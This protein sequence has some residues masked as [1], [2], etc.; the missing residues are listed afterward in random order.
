MAAGNNPK[1]QLE[2]DVDSTKARAGFEEVS[3]S[4]QGMARSV[5]ESGRKAGGGLDGVAKGSEQAAQRLDRSTKSIIAQI[6]RVTAEM[7]AGEKG[8][9]TYFESLARQRGANV[10]ALRPYLAQLDAAKSKQNEFSQSLMNTGMSARATAAALRT[11]PAQFTDIVTSLQSGQAP[12][13]VLLQQGGQ[14]NDQFGGVGA[15]AQALGRYIAGLVNPFT[16]AAGAL[17]ALAFAAYQGSEE[18]REFQK[19]LI[20]SGDRAGVTAD[21]LMQI[22]DSIDQMNDGITRARAAEV[23]NEI[24]RS[25]VRG[26]DQIRRL[27]DTAARFEQVGGGA[28]EEVAKAFKALAEDPLGASMK[29]NEAIGYL[30]EST[31]KQIKA[32]VDQGRT[33]EAA[34]LAIG[35]YASAIENRI[36]KLADNLGSIQRAW[37]YVK[38]EAA[39]AWDAMLGIGRAE[40][41]GDR[42]ADIERRLRE[43]VTSAPAFGETYAQREQETQRLRQELFRLR[44]EAARESLGAR[45]RGE[46]AQREKERIAFLA[47]GDKFLDSEAKKQKEIAQI[48]QLRLRNVISE[49]EAKE[50]IA[51]I[52]QS[53]AKG[54][55]SRSGG[56]RSTENR[57]LKEQADLLATLSGVNRDYVEQLARVQSMRESGLITE[58]QSID[59]LIALIEKQPMARDLMNEQAEATKRLAQEQAALAKAEQDRINAA[60]RSAAGVQDQVQKLLDEERALTIAAASNISLAQAI[61]EVNIARLREQQAQLMAQGDRD[62]EVLAIQKEIDARK[63]LQ[64]AIGRQEAREEAKK[65]AD[66][67]AKEWQKTADAIEQTLTDALMRG[68]ESGK[69]FGE[70]LAD[71]IVNTFKTYVAR[72]IAKAI[73]NAILSAIAGQNWANIIG[74]VL[75]G[76]QGGGSFGNIVTSVAGDYAKSAI[77]NYLGAGAGAGAAAAGSTLG[78]ATG[79]GF[80]VSAAGSGFG[81]TATGTGFGVSATTTGAAAVGGG[82]VAGGATTATGGALAGASSALAAIP[83]WGWVAIAAIALWQPLFGRKLKEVGTQINFREGD[84]S[85]NDYKFEKGGWFRS[86]KTTMLGD[87]TDANKQLVQQAENIQESA[88]GM[89]RALGFGT[90]AIDSF[91]GTVNVNMKGV[92]SNEEAAQR[93]NEALMELQRQMLNAATGANMSKEAFAEWINGINQ[94][95][96]DAGISTQGIADILVQGM[97]GRLSQQEVGDQL[98]DMI[99]GGIYNSIASNYA[100]QIAQAF[101]A[102]IITPIFT[103]LAAGVPISQAISQQAIAN[104]VA[105]AQQAAAALNAIFNDAGFKAAIAGVEQAIG[106]VAS[107]ATSVKVPKILSARSSGR[108]SGPSPA[109]IEADRIA[110]EREGLERQ[111]LQLQG[112][113]VELRRRE[114]QELDPSNR[115]L[116]ERIWALEEEQRISQERE[117]IERRM[118]ELNGRQA[119]LRAM[120]LAALDASN[121]AL[122]EHVWALEDQA[123]AASQAAGL[124]RNLMQALGDTAG[125]R[126]ME[127]DAI[128]PSARYLQEALWAVEDAAAAEEK[129]RQKVEEAKSA[130]RDAYERE[131]GEIQQTIDK[132]DAFAR[133]LKAFRQQL[134]IDNNSPLSLTQ[135]QAE[136]ERQ[137]ADVARRARLGDVDAIAELQEISS[138][139]LAVSMESAKSAEDYYRSFAKVQN[140]LDDTESLAQRQIDMAERQLEELQQQVQGLIDINESV[141][142]VE[143]AVRNVNSA[144]SGLAAATIS[145]GSA[146]EAAKKAIEIYKEQ[147]RQEQI[148][149]NAIGGD[150]SAANSVAANEVRALYESIGRVGNIAPSLAEIAYWARQNLSIDELKRTFLTAAS[151]ATGIYAS[152]AEIAQELLKG[153]RGYASGGVHSGGLRIVGENGPELELT[154]PSRIW[155]AE[156]TQRMLS[157]SANDELVAEVRQ[158]RKEMAEMKSA[159]AATARNSNDT[160]KILQRVTNGGNAMLTEAVA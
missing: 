12:L 10:D 69:G 111:L 151:G 51:K 13:T 133:S 102:Q 22:A 62:A 156:Q 38:K 150:S 35:E 87:T 148:A 113:T 23:L 130:L 160:V 91:S 45:D 141:L 122:Q 71:S 54:G 138:D 88:K 144:I 109:Q 75:G 106:G 70:S 20:L 44:T 131:R 110:K 153:I 157:G 55:S 15:A 74:G 124:V 126:Q 26:E 77:S 78:T 37:A 90:D 64:Q 68:F 41:A 9:S 50:R 29:L 99:V 82:A 24:V 159:A 83:V 95:I 80:G 72:E 89:A 143:Q 36:P 118:L 145:K 81:A 115:A 116:Q 65:A 73:S 6:Q 53:Y 79:T 52:E 21:Q 123:N 11:V 92:K 4:A 127:L 142:S 17:G 140:V 61:E 1:V 18:F 84:I 5:E 152:S 158:L 112:D 32:L 76:G 66:E 8:S 16:V 40:T 47:A 93:Y 134:L 135:R 119:Q 139:Y 67:A 132:F 94:S 108:A 98:A 85:T 49:A 14:L 30:T 129:A 154:G 28:A 27:T 149:L 48:Q 86:D 33:T 19:T 60:E 117:G 3:K 137:F 43:R 136:A 104:V 120:D 2:F 155:S 25:G 105:T 39:E 101:T 58:Q 103:A 121:R 128:D 96:A 100:A 34:T 147:L 146:E 125:L 42:I 56:G 57:E 97:M 107:A 31:Y 114:L 59:L 63:Q 7:Q 46:A